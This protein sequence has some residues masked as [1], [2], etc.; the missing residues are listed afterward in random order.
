MVGGR[1]KVNSQYYR[2][3]MLF[4]PMNCGPDKGSSGLLAKNL[5]FLV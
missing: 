5:R 3:M 1:S 2:P 4:V